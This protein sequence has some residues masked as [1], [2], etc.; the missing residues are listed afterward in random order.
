VVVEAGEHTIEMRYL[1][2]TV[3]LGGLMTLSAAILAFVLGRR[4]R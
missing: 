2:G 4:A 1:P 3:V